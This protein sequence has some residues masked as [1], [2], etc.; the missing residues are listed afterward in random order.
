[1]GK[2]N[3]KFRHFLTIEIYFLGKEGIGKDLQNK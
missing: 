3:L 1:M 2:L